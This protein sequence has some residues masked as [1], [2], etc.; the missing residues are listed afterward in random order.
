MSESRKRDGGKWPQMKVLIASTIVPFLRGGGTYLVDTLAHKIRA[1]GHEVDVLMLPFWSYWREMIPQML[2]L[3]LLDVRRSGD[4]LICV[5]TPSYM[6]EHPNKVV[7]FL[8]HHR[9]AYDLW[10]YS[11]SMDRS[12]EAIQARDAFFRAD[13]E[14]LSTAR[15]VFALSNNV[16]ERLWNFNRVKSE[17]LMA[18]L[19]N[20]ERYRCDSYGDYFFYPS[21]ITTMKRQWLAIEAM[22]YVKS[23]VKLVIAGQP[24]D[25]TQARLIKEAFQSLGDR[26]NVKLIDRWITEEEKI[27]L[28][29]NT[30]ACLFVPYEEDW[31]YVTLEAFYAKKA[32]VCLKDSGGP[33]GLIEH[34]KSGLIVDPEPE[35]LAAAMDKLYEN[36]Q[37][38][39]RMGE[40]AFERLGD[41]HI[42][43]DHVTERLLA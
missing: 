2:A 1:L 10:G 20:P 23:S 31:G 6:L 28:M 26:T 37:D 21:R 12:P 25:G 15:T 7:W 32:V 24:D 3:R 4:R 41:L 9:D 36:R 13:N 34:G 33:V 5:R 19:L 43:W 17:V 30:L 39:V 22:K 27:D 35:A 38:A 8:H 11:T 40:A 29:S 42:S 16:A 14:A 18:P